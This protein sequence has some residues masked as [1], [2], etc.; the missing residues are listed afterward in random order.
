MGGVIKK[1]GEFI[2][3]IVESI[4]EFV[5]DIFS[6]L[7]AP[8]GA[9]DM[10]DAP[11]ADQAAQG[12]TI[13]KQGTNQAIP[14]VYGY[15][16]VG[17][18]IVHAETG[19]DNNK[20]LWV[21][22]AIS[23][24]EIEGIKRIIVDDLAMPLPNEY[25]TFKAG[26]FYAD[27]LKYDVPNGRFKSRILFQCFYG[28]SSNTPAPS[29]MSD[30]PIWKTKNR[31]MPGVA[32]MAARFEWKEIKT[33][34]DSNN[35]PFRGGIPKLQ[36]DLCGKKIYNVRGAPVVGA[37]DLTADY[38]ALPKN[39]NTN[40][41]NCLLDYLMSPRHGAGIPKEQ[42]NAYSFWI[43]ATKYDQTVTYNNKYV[44]KA[45]TTNAVIDTNT[46]ILSNA[47]LI[48]AGGRG[49][50]PYI[51]GRYKLK[52]EDGGNE[53][54]ITSTTIT[55]AYDVDKDTIIGGISLQGERKKTKLNQ[56]IVN[57]IDPDLEFTNQQVFYNESGDEAIDNNEELSK[58]FTFHTITNKAM[59]WENARL[60]YKKSRKQRSIS[61]RG[62]QELHSVE[63]GDVIRVTDSILQLSN[64]TFRITGLELNP[65][66]TVNI[67]AV[68]HD[69]T[70]YPFTG[71]V[72]Q[73][74]IPPPVYLPDELNLR[75][76]Q[77]VIND[78]PFGIVPPNGDPDSSG[79][80]EEVNPLPPREE[81]V[82]TQVTL[83]QSRP[84]VAP[85]NTSITTLDGLGIEGY[86]HNQFGSFHLAASA[87]KGLLYHNPLIIGTDYEN[88][89]VYASA[90]TSTINGVTYTVNKPIQNDY[91][92]FRNSST[93][94]SGAVNYAQ[95][96]MLLNLPSNSGYNSVLIRRFI[97]QE[98]IDTIDSGIE[99]AIQPI[100]I[101]NANL[102]PGDTRT[103]N[104]LQFNW[105][106]VT[107]G[108]KEYHQDGSNLGNYTYY[109][110]FLG[111]NITG[112][113]IEA[114]IN[115]LIQNP[116]TA[117]AGMTEGVSP[118]GGDSKLTTHNLGA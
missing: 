12:V 96:I 48:I 11:Q 109:N 59:A 75:P 117:V 86:Q 20:Y 26:G 53:F 50:M 38:A 107:T 113:N 80:A 25:S 55:V 71:G 100:S 112:T 63:V 105:G 89:L 36:F 7:L 66:L 45:M 15:R 34:D 40:P 61:F 111:K 57:Y 102:L 51:Q 1:I 52:V 17:G 33:Q 118:G 3:N 72:G 30:A 46:K 74:D 69:A 47:K 13:S 104:Y 24:G 93:L 22:W 56:A 4:V 28:G 87:D 115:Y 84:N 81:Q 43:A 6:F 54:D 14:I 76:R 65:D 32:Y 88:S 83:F 16:R 78:P 67:A 39:Y 73:L 97:N 110:P 70:M 79:E 101:H 94:A 114:Y 44:G 68:E 31:T 60:I 29:V 2:G 23:E 108:K 8:F 37:L 116:Y 18:I 106:K 58:E 98:Q 82:N 99:G 5:G 85:I 42:I 9:P 19:S 62:T 91:L 64:A 103:I 95:V 90:Q 77:R 41:A 27:G 92:I 35:N 21:V 49:I 10:P